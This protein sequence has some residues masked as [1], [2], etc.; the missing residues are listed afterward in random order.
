MYKNKPLPALPSEAN[1]QNSAI[2]RNQS[3]VGTTSTQEDSSFFDERTEHANANND[4]QFKTFDH[5]QYAKDEVLDI[6]VNVPHDEWMHMRNMIRRTEKAEGKKKKWYQCQ[7]P[8]AWIIFSRSITCW[9][10]LI[11]PLF[12]IRGKL[13]QQAWREKFALFTIII[14]ICTIDKMQISILGRVYNIKGFPHPT[15]AGINFSNF[16]RTAGGNDL[17]FMFQQ[18]NLHCKG[19]FIPIQPADSSG[20]VYNYFPCILLSINDHI[21]PNSSLNPEKSGCHGS[22]FAKK[23]ISVLKFSGD[24][25]Y[26]WDDVRSPDRNYIVYNGQV[27]DMDRLQWIVPNIRLP[28]ILKPMMIKSTNMFHG[29][30]MTF[31]LQKNNIQLAKCMEEILRIGVID[32]ISIGCVIS[33][34]V[35]SVTLTIIVGSFRKESDVEEKLNESSKNHQPPLNDEYNNKNREGLSSSIS[36]VNQSINTDFLKQYFDFSLKYTI[37]LVAAEH[38]DNMHDLRTTLDSLART[39]YPTSHK[40]MMCIVDDNKMP[41]TNVYVSVMSDFITSPDEVVSHTCVSF[42]NNKKEF[43]MIKIYAGYYKYRSLDGKV[44]NVPMITMVKYASEEKKD[45]ASEIFN[46]RDSKII[47]MNFLKHVMFN[48]KMNSLE[49]ELFTVIRTIC[50]VT[51]D[52]FELVLMVDVNTKVYPDSL[53]HMI[54]CMSHDD[55][56]TGICGEIEIFNKSDTWVTMIQVFEYYITHLQRAFESIFGC[57]TC[58]PSCFCM[59][60]IK[61]T[62]S[63]DGN[64][65][66]ILINPTIIEQYSENILDTVH[67]KNLHLGENHYLTTLLLQ[68]FPKRKTVF[69]PK[70]VCVIVASNTFYA[71]LSESLRSINS[72]IHNL[73]ELLLIPNLCGTFCFSMKFA[74]FL[75]LVNIVVLPTTT[76]FFFYLIIISSVDPYNASFF[77][78]FFRTLV[79]VLPAIL[80][81]LITFISRREITNFIWMII[82]L[83]SMPLRSFI[84]PIYAFW[85][86]DNFSWEES[87]TKKENFDSSRII[88]KQWV[89]WEYEN[90]LKRRRQYSIS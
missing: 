13:V 82:Y 8:S 3:R 73:L 42:A 30:D 51:P 74:I 39:D 48:E 83:L 87:I 79:L 68:M 16:E 80:I 84:I 57:V 66:P 15:F 53:A 75:R 58:L 46:K 81:F 65:I 33:N 72:T 76:I 52:Y 7:F 90:R 18:V 37:L 88:T 12:E 31:F 9:T 59:Y 44:H 5:P 2:I 38:S 20:N 77:T 67:K 27:F 6:E 56:I 36:S 55:K 40:L 35:S 28:D 41:T 43:K 62:R 26:N 71:F 17:T 49:Y 47:L 60:R 21:A 4:G 14:T 23:A 1:R 32:T 10:P 61:V 22:T 19:L 25:Y 45:P 70:A 89:D 29:Q 69:V 54:A 50:K 11:L 63:S 64:W 85:H 78:L 34:A 86:F 24:I